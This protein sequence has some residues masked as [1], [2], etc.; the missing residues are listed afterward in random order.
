[1][2]AAAV[3]SL[4]LGSPDDNRRAVRLCDAIVTDYPKSAE[5]QEALKLR[6]ELG[7]KR[8]K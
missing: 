4:Q 2:L 5:A 3:T 1:M 6:Q 7:V 8:S